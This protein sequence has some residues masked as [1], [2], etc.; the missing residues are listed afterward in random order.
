ML[1]VNAVAGMS[2]YTSYINIEEN[3]QESYQFVICSDLLMIHNAINAIVISVHQNMDK[4][5]L[6]CGI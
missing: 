3:Y 1:N 2:N 6:Q 5:Y 4:P